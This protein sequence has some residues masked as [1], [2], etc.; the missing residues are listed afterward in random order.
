M[1]R[2]TPD[3]PKTLMLC[4]LLGIRKFQA[5]GILESIWHWAARYAIQ[6]DIGKWSNSAIAKG[7]EWD[8]NP[9]ELIG[10]LVKV[11][12]LDEVKLPHRLVIHDIQDHADN[13]WRQSLSDACLTFWDG[14]HHASPVERTA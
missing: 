13:S 5:V 4:D 6:G 12:W 8:G 3:H 7:I 1:K 10:A 2:G 14:T 9:D 11:G